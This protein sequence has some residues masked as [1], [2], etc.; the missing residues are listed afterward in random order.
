MRQRW[1]EKVNGGFKGMVENSASSRKHSGTGRVTEF[2]GVGC[3]G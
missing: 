2:S 1:W 3:S